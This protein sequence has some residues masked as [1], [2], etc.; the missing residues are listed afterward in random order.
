MNTIYF[1]IPYLWRKILYKQYDS[2]QLK[3]ILW[4]IWLVN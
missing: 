4:W 3:V 1:P 2:Y